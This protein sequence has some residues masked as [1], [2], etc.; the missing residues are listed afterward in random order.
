VSGSSV[1]V[2][3]VNDPSFSMSRQ[4]TEKHWNKAAVLSPLVRAS[5]LLASIPTSFAM[6]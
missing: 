1:V 3:V 6:K 4:C 5:D 2:V